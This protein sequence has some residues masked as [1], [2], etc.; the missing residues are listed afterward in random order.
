MAAV[1]LVAGGM[2]PAG[3]I[4]VAACLAAATGLSVRF[5][6][7]RLMVACTLISAPEA[8]ALVAAE[9]G[10]EGLW[11]A[12]ICVFTGLYAF[13]GFGAG[14]MPSATRLAWPWIPASGAFA[15]VGI[16]LIS[17]AAGGLDVAGAGIGSAGLVFIAFSFSLRLPLA[18]RQ[19]AGAVRDVVM[20]FRA[21]G[22]GLVAV[23]LC[24]W[25][26]GMV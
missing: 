8:L 1:P 19:P 25:A 9:E 22:L 20:A 14:V 12:T 16:L 6:W 3:I 13:A 2:G 11:W 15:A 5:G 17:E 26:L 18:Q 7:R 24:A 21:T 23:G 4:V 10:G